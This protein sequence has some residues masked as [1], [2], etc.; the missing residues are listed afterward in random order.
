MPADPSKT[1]SF[2]YLGHYNKKNKKNA[3]RVFTFL[4]SVAE[5]NSR[6]E[7]WIFYT[8]VFVNK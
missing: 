4:R 8:N 5:F 7:E 6:N 2:L 1:V 3:T